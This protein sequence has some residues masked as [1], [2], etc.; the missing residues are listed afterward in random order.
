MP[1]DTQRTFF[2]V[3]FASGTVC[4]LTD[5]ENGA[6]P[7]S[8]SWDGFRGPRVVAEDSSRTTVRYPSYEYADYTLNALEGRFS[9]AVTKDIDFREYTGRILVTLRMYRALSQIGTKESLHILS[10]RQVESTDRMLKQAQDD[11]M[12]T[13]SGPIYRFD[14]F[15]DTNAT[16]PILQQY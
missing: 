10:F 4:P 13:L 11:T 16:P 7:G 15:D 5:E 9:I 8:T 3:R 12:T 14:V 1:P 6:A 2:R